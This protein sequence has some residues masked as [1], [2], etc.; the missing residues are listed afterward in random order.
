MFAR[1][2]FDDLLDDAELPEEVLPS[3]RFRLPTPRG[4]ALAQGPLNHK[5][6]PT[7]LLEAAG[8]SGSSRA[9]SS[10]PAWPAPA[11]QSC[12]SLDAGSTKTPPLLV[13]GVPHT[14]ASPPSRK[15]DQ[16]L[17][18]CTAEGDF[19][20]TPQRGRPSRLANDLSLTPPVIQQKGNAF[21]RMP[22]AS[23]LG[24]NLRKLGEPALEAAVADT[25]VDSSTGETSS[26]PLSN[27]GAIGSQSTSCQE[28]APDASLR[29]E[30]Y[31]RRGIIASNRV[32]QVLKEDPDVDHETP[33]SGTSP[34]ADAKTYNLQATLTSGGEIVPYA[35]AAES[36]VASQTT[37]TSHPPAKKRGR[38]NSYFEEV[39]GTDL[40]EIPADDFDLSWADRPKRR[41]IPTLEFWRGEKVIYERKSGDG[42]SAKAVVVNRAGE[43][44]RLRAIED[45]KAQLAIKDKAGFN[46]DQ[47]A[48]KDK[49]IL[50]CESRLS[51]KDKARL[52]RESR[53]AIKDKARLERASQ[54]AI[55]DKARR[56]VPKPKPKSRQQKSR[57]VPDSDE[58]A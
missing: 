44:E 38:R 50:D 41:R 45:R 43:R 2:A 25:Y 15:V 34:S 55:K 40:V 37:A 56:P 33:S 52:E 11:A 54:L 53:L 9:S 17:D 22:S 16:V 42:L 31:R 57:R 23:Q 4:I 36:L 39:R 19:A 1:A 48:I 14:S 47:L 49:A 51:I 7:T 27:T 24:A 18:A 3:D 26:P 35:D 20:T 21:L 5:P 46:S 58:S 29:M 28:T 32:P 6:L 8:V 12:G 13:S 30:E 10:K